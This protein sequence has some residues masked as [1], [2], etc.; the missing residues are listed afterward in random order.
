[1]VTE[2]GTIRTNAAVMAGGGQRRPFAASSAS[3]SR[4]RRSAP[5]SL[6]VS[7]GA[8][9]L[10]DALHTA[11]ISAT[12]RGDGRSTLAISGR[13]SV[14]MTP[15]LLRFSSQFVPMFLKRWRS[16]GPGGLQG[17]RSGR[18]NAATLA[19]RPA[20]ADGADAHP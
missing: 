11:K 1:M 4:K 5:P 7:P 20:D 15:Q 18:R 8:E 16:L 6:S 14:D 3:A 12:R 2:S 17:V 10:P 13:G 9:G 19:A